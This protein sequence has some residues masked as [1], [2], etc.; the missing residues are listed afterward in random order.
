MRKL[1]LFAAA[2]LVTA[3]LFSSCTKN[4]DNIDPNA[5]ANITALVSAN[6]NLSLLR[7]AVVRAGLAETLAGS[8]TFTVFAPDNDAFI[9]ADLGTVEKINAMPVDQ[10]RAVLLYHVL[11]QQYTAASIAAGTTEV[12]TVNTAKAYVVKNGSA[13][14]INGAVV[15]QADIQASNGI[16]HIIN[17]VIMP[18]SANIVA[19]A[20]GNTNLTFLV[21]AIV[22]ASTGSTNVAQ[23]LS[24]N[25]PYTV[26]APTNAAFIKAGFSSIASIQT[27]D[28]NTLASILTYHVIA[29][30]VLS[31]N[32]TEGAEPTTLNGAKVKI[33]LSGGA[34][35]KGNSNTTAANITAT[36]MVATNG[37]VHLID[38]VLKP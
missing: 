32:L 33:T 13:V 7:A 26:F 35:V 29:A 31:S 37:V 5:N 38:D 17:K 8:G 28:P 2:L 11:G 12:T 16:V 23:V 27:A 25:G 36:D 9:A 34:K 14:S 24:G 30:R 22:R 1:K 15:K 20:Q 10:L 19:M 18:P 3:G 6:A 21:A 4:N